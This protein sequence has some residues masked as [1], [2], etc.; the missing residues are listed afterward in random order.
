[1]SMDQAKKYGLKVKDKLTTEQMDK[2][3]SGTGK[4]VLKKS[5]EYIELGKGTFLEIYRDGKSTLSELA[6][7]AGMADKKEWVRRK[8]EELLVSG[9]ITKEELQSLGIKLKDGLKETGETV[10][11]AVVSSASYTTTN[12]SNAVNNISNGGGGSSQKLINEKTM[13][14]IAMGEVLF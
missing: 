5:G 12:I 11:N 13:D 3:W 4:Q 8:A 2:A 6:D 7:K 1:M 9:E 10:G 14:D